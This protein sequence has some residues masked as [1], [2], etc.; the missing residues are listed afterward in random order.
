MVTSSDFEKAVSEILGEL[1]P[2]DIKPWL[3]KADIC[4]QSVSLSGEKVLVHD[5][6]DLLT[7]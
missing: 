5:E 3:I 2:A 7:M 6:R 4:N 1:E